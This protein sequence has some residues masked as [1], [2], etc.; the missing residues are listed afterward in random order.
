MRGAP[1]CSCALRRA[2]CAA[3]GVTLPTRSPAAQR[4]LDDILREVEAFGARVVEITGGEPMLQRE[5]HGVDGRRCWTPGPR[6]PTRNRRS[7]PASTT[8]R[9]QLWRLLTSSV[10]AAASQAKMLWS[11]LE[12]L[13]P[14][15]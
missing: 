1:A 12:Q 5:V 14:H 8:C 10:R 6:S 15:V 9:R 11:N 2:I 3:P 4:S 13:S 7:P